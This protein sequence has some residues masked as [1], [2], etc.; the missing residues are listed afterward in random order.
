MSASSGSFLGTVVGYV[1][2]QLCLPCADAMIKRAQNLLAQY[3][4][5]DIAQ[6]RVLLRIPGERLSDVHHVRSQ[7]K[8]VISSEPCV[9]EPTV[10]SQPWS[11]LA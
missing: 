8:Q 3:K 7:T 2:L 1:R 4:E 9:V 11:C 6:D 10:G 5:M